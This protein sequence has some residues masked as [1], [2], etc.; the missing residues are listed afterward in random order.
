MSR[1][2][3]MFERKA[4]YSVLMAVS[5]IG[6]FAYALFVLISA[7]MGPYSA[8]MYEAAVASEVHSPP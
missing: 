4:S 5:D 8:G 1:T 3:N 7:L 2:T 6:G